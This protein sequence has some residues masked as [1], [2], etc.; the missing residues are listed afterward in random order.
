MNKGSNSHYTLLLQDETETDGVGME[1]EEEI[2]DRLNGIEEEEEEEEEEDDD[3]P[4]EDSE[5][6]IFSSSKHR[7]LSHHEGPN[8][9]GQ[10]HLVSPTSEYR[11]L[12]NND[13]DLKTVLDN[14]ITIWT[15]T[16]MSPARRA[17]FI[18][19]IMLGILVVA[20]F[21]WVLPCDVQPCE[22][23]VALRDREWAVK[24][25]GMGINETRLVKRLGGGNNV[26]L[27]YYISSNVSAWDANSSLLT[28]GEQWHMDHSQTD[29]TNCG[30]KSSSSDNEEYCGLLMLDGNLGRENWRIPLRECSV[31][32]QCDLLDVSGDGFPDCIIRGLYSM[33]FM[34]EARYGTTLWHL[35]MHNKDKKDI[36]PSLA[37]GSSKA[38]QSSL[39][40]L[41]PS[42]ALLLPDVNDDSFGDL[43]FSGLVTSD[44][45]HPSRNEHTS[46]ETSWNIDGELPE[47]ASIQPIT[48]HLV[49]V[50]GQSGSI[51]G[52]PLVL[53]QCQRI[54]SI[55]LDGQRIS[56]SCINSKSERHAGMILLSALLDQ[57]LG[58][59]APTEKFDAA[60][61]PI[62]SNGRSECEVKV[63]TQG[64]CPLCQSQVQLSS[65]HQVLWQSDYEHSTV[66][67]W[68]PLWSH[69]QCHG[70]VLK[71]WE[72][73][74]ITNIEKTAKPPSG[75]RRTT[76]S[77]L[78]SEEADS[79]ETEATYL[80]N[81]HETE[82]NVD[83]IAYEG[84]NASKYDDGN[85]IYNGL[86]KTQSKSDQSNVNEITTN[87]VQDNLAIQPPTTIE[88]PRARRDFAHNSAKLTYDHSNAHR[89]HS[90]QVASSHEDQI[91]HPEA[92]S[93]NEGFHPQ[94]SKEMKYGDH[95]QAKK[96]VTTP[97][98]PSSFP[99]GS[100]ILHQ[101]VLAPLGYQLQQIHERLA[102][103]KNNGTAWHEE[104]LTSLGLGITQLCKS[105]DACLPSL[106]SHAKSVEVTSA[107]KLREWQV[108]SSS[109]TFVNSPLHGEQHHTSP[110]SLTS[111][112][113][114]ILVFV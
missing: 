20:T 110:W 2:E 100:R 63:T 93:Q 98:L 42:P 48:N 69:N 95:H 27:S 71:V 74:H 89:H 45:T 67:A 94:E 107:V 87:S 114:K 85:V 26:V 56:Y 29:C 4:I 108:V 61:K 57:I 60:H 47:P 53:K 78:V 59:E 7:T 75:N 102:L 92:G 15:P 106:E 83:S 105:D 24:I 36:P 65:G 96:G 17:C 77:S 62:K 80:E 43:L 97:I 88:S 30:A 86:F 5:E 79:A 10:N 34:V 104:T 90:K 73:R 66:V 32:L 76:R 40:L 23:D 16:P 55:A 13:S 68:A 1:E 111:I 28:D 14:P 113:R 31:D 51:L 91:S 39:K 44:S 41:H 49:L 35:H 54:L 21:L 8:L 103:L 50:C 101:N 52:A 46:S 6:E 99:T 81:N 70:A 109:T 38:K 82:V 11:L 84:N 9:N 3:E 12:N 72:W 25:E 37:E 112:V 33:L 22:G 19:S 58:D 64:I 18:A